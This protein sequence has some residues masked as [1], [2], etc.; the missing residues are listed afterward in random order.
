[1][2]RASRKLEGSLRRASRGLA[3]GFKEVSRA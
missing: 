1:V 3:K 2:K